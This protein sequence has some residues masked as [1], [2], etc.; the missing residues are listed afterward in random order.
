MRKSKKPAKLCY[1]CR[2]RKAVS[3]RKVAKHGNKK[4]FFVSKDHDLCLACWRDVGNQHR[5]RGMKDEPGSQPQ[6][7]PQ[8]P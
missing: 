8:E 7:R 6:A 3:M 4:K 1:R 2:K 5:A